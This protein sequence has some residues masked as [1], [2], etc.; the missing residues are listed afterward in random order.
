MYCKML[1]RDAAKSQKCL[2][3]FHWGDFCWLPLHKV[4]EPVCPHWVPFDETPV[5]LGRKGYVG[6][7][8]ALEC[9]KTIIVNHA[10]RFSL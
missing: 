5:V 3:L 6:D 10:T 8:L 2:S 1:V 4:Q 9:A 7:L